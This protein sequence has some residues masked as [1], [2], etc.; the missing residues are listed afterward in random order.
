MFTQRPNACA[1]TDFLIERARRRRS[2]RPCGPRSNNARVNELCRSNDCARGIV[3]EKK[4]KKKQRA[5]TYLLDDV[6]GAYVSK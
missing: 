1:R 3:V 5:C 6:F 2:E 4:K